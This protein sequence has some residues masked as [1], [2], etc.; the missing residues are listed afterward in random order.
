MRTIWLLWG[1]GFFGVICVVVGNIYSSSV[2]K[3]GRQSAQYQAW[4][5]NSNDFS[6]SGLKKSQLYLWRISL[7]SRWIGGGLGFI[8]IFIEFVFLIFRKG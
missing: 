3:Y 2:E 5:K 6:P 8:Y 7:I 4:L 1:C